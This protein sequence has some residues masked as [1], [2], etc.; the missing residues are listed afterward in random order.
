MKSLTI[1]NFNCNRKFIIIF[2]FFIYNIFA[3]ESAQVLLE[4]IYK[5][6]EFNNGYYDGI[7]TIFLPYKKKEVYEFSMLKKEKS[8]FW[9]IKKQEQM[10]YRVLCKNESNDIYIY[11]KLRDF[12]KRFQQ[13]DIMKNWNYIPV[14]LYCN[15][16]L[17]TILDPQKK[18]IHNN[19]ILILSNFFVPQIYY[20]S[21]IHIDTDYQFRKMLIFKKHKDIN[22]I[23][24]RIFYFYDQPISILKEN[25][26]ESIKTNYPTELEIIDAKN[27]NVIKI[28]WIYFHP[29]YK[30]D[31][32]RFMPEFISK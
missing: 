10:K 23:E 3:E 18:E 11:D 6:N 28:Q 24:F 22:H 8:V 17:E 29:N 27:R 30:I 31:D 5:K 1:K 32:I 20:T 7:I 12:L 19:E 16:P 21:M 9:D 14:F 13:Q 15:V 25:Q 2:L 4:K 26:I